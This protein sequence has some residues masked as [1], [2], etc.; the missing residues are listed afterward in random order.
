MSTNYGEHPELI[1]VGMGAT[2][3]T[4]MG[5]LYRAYTVTDVKRGG[6]LLRLQEDKVT[7]VGENRGWEDTAEKTFEPDPNGRIE[8]VS[9]RKD[10][11]F[12]G[13]G[14]PMVWYATRYHIGHRRDWT[15]YSQ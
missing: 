2:M 15:D 6:K 8:Y 3:R 12:I 1:E 4:G 14:A 13:K 10:G 7:V 11:T 9:L 5:G